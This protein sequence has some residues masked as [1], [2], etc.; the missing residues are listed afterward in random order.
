MQDLVAYL[1]LLVNPSD[2]VS[3]R[4][5]LN[6]PPRGLGGRK[7]VNDITA[8]TGACVGGCPAS[9]CGPVCQAAKALLAGRLEGHSRAVRVALQGFVDFVRHTAEELQTERRLSA[10]E[11][12]WKV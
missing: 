12:L 1:A 4:R 6:V 11:V 7:L 9:G 10:L 8:A 5:V 3:F 2:G